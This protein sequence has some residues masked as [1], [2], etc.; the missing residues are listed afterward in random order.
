[1]TKFQMKRIYESAASDDGFRVLIDRLWPRGISKEEADI[2]LWEKDIAP[3]NELREDFHE[4][5]DSWE[6]FEAK[7]RA[8]LLGNPAL[9]NFIETIRSKGIV[10]LLFAAKDVDHTH[11][12]VIMS[13]LQE[14]M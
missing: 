11:V 3:T 9:E 12:K 5:R 7:Y 6:V 2:D 4:G 10:T 13:V 1:M 14:K 8:E